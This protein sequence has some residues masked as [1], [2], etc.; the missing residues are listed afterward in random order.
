MK[1]YIFTLFVFLAATLSTTN[2][3]QTITSTENEKKVTHV[4]GNHY[5]VVYTDEEGNVLQKGQYF[6]VGERLKPHGIWKLY[7]H[8]TFELVTTAKYD[9]GDQLWVET[10]IDGQKIKID[11]YQL[12]VKRL[13]D[14][15]AALEKQV[16]ESELE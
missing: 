2:A 15:I 14:R 16:N 8:N 11:K 10:I 1:K 4:I 3:Q 7:D 5:D 6:K 13:E 9:K 12:L